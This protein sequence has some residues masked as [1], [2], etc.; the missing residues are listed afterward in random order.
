MLLVKSLLT[1]ISKSYEQNYM[2]LFSWGFSE[3]LTSA[4]NF[5]LICGSPVTKDIEFTWNDPTE[6]CNL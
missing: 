1:L 6:K 2:E 3:S 5:I 4:Q